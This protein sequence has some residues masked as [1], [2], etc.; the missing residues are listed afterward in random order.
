MG[1]FGSGTVCTMM[2]IAPEKIP[3]DPIPAMARPIMKALEFGA[4][5]QMAEPISKSPIV[6]RNT[7]LGL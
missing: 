4:A 1:L 3:D 7:H 2:I 6:E 5:P